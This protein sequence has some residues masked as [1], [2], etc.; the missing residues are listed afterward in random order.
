MDAVGVA[1][2]DDEG[3]LPAA[4]DGDRRDHAAFTRLVALHDRDLVRL[5]YLV[6][7]SWDA[8]EDA[9]QATWERLWRMPP[10]LRDGTRLRSWL[11]TVV[12]N[13]ARQAGRRRRRGLVLEAAAT[14]APGEPEFDAGLADLAAAVG[15]LA[16]GDRELLGLRFALGMTSSEIGA[17]LGLSA[18]GV[19]SRLHR[20]LARIR[21]D[22]DRG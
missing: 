8:A 15:R 10:S 16:D 9:A 13:E 19:R 4:A 12:A 20:L 14:S 17:H 7:G 3:L 21:E 5:A 1:A 6:A 22:L 18:E 2:V 11:L